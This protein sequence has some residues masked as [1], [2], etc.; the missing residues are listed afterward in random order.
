[1]DTAQQF[2]WTLKAWAVLPNHYHILAEHKGES[3]R[4]L[5]L[6][7]CC[8]HRTSASAINELHRAPGRRVWM[9]YRE[10]LI[11]HHTSY[12]ARLN[13]VNQNPVKH[14][15][16]A[17]AVDYRWCSAAWFERSAPRSFVTS[18]ARFKSDRL[19]VWDDFD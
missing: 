8:L 19:G 7:L 1:M 14:G 5:Q 6:W 16:A 2:H 13:Y 17:C 3:A 15:L 11:T 12:L 4:S 18:V 9:N 10:T